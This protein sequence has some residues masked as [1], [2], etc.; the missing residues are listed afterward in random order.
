VSLKLYFNINSI[1]LIKIIKFVTGTP[2]RFELTFILRNLYIFFR[3]F[4]R[5]ASDN[6]E[7]FNI[8]RTISF[9]KENVP[10][11]I[12]KELCVVAVHETWKDPEFTSKLLLF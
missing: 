4:Q 12:L 11:H 5:T 10:E 1:Y 2:K 9:F 6:D 3:P 7:I 8:L